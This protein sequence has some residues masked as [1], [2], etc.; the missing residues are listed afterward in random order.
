MSKRKHILIIGAERGLGL[1]LAQQFFDR[2]WHVVGTARHGDNVDALTAVG[3]QDATRL[4]LAYIDVTQAEHIDELEKALGERQFD[5]IFMNA[6]IFGALHQS[7]LE[8]TPQEV[9]QIM[10]TNAI[11]PVR[12]A[13]RL[14]A[15]LTGPAP[16]I[17]FM[18]SY[19]ASV[20]DRKSV[21]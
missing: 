16:T 3:S 10:M 19:R 11:G 14:S 6:G 9:T 20:R 1:G 7:V 17:C 15:R 5:V 18:S 2:G 13:R 4:G 12:I 21:V 8:A